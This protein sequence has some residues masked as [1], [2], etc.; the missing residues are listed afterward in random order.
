MIFGYLGRLLFGGGSLRAE[1]DGVIVFS[2][3]GESDS[4]S[5]QISISDSIYSK[6]GVATVGQSIISTGERMESI[7]CDKLHIESKITPD[8]N[9]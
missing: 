2:A 5:S 6:I 7:I 9:T 4:F 1:V 3:I 8:E